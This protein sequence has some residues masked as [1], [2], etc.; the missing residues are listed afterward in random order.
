MG[1]STIVISLLFV[2][3]ITNVWDV[4]SRC[5]NRMG[6]W[7]VQTSDDIYSTFFQNYPT[8]FC[9]TPSLEVESL[10]YATD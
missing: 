7:R 3:F 10:T 4:V 1:V 2:I 5:E 8:Y 9:E 6:L